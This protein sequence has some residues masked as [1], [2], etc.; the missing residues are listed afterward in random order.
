[1]KHVKK[2]FIAIMVFIMAITIVP[3][4]IST[5]KNKIRL[6]K[7]SV[8]LNIGEKTTLKVKGTSKKI[9]W[10][11]L[12]KKIATV[13]KKGVVKGK[14][15]G[16]TIIIAKV[17]KNQYACKI[18]VEDKED[19]NDSD[20]DYY[21][22]SDDESSNPYYDDG[23][24]PPTPKPTVAPTPK[25]TIIPTVKPTVIQEQNNI[26]YMGDVAINYNSANSE[27]RIFFS[28]KTSNGTRIA[29]LG[30][31]NITIINNNNI[32]VYKKDI[33]FIKNNFSNWTNSD[34]T[35]YL[36]CLK[37]PDLDIVAG[38]ISTG[39]IYLTVKTETGSRFE[40]EPYTI[41]HLPLFKYSSQCS[42]IIDD[43]TVWYNKE[44]NLY[45]ITDVSYNFKDTNIPGKVNLIIEYTGTRIAKTYDLFFYDI[46]LYLNDIL[47]DTRSMTTSTYEGEVEKKTVTFFNIDAGYYHVKFTSKN[48]TTINNTTSIPTSAPTSTTKPSYDN[49][50]GYGTVSGNITYHY[51]QYMGYVADTGARVILIPKDG[52]AKSSDISEVLF[53]VLTEKTLRDKNIYSA[54]V[55]GAGNYSVNHIPEGEYLIFIISNKCSTG[56]WFAAYDDTISDAA[57]TYYKNI[58][59]DSGLNLYLNDTT[60]FNLV[61]SIIFYDYKFSSI[62]VYGNSNTTVSHAF[63]YTYT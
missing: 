54:K 38:D 53:S 26:K 56:L 36:C 62:S 46:R 48:S 7:T 13:S 2:M 3:S 51:N 52:S 49:N 5:A 45:S 21:D 63:P 35:F 15:E 33:D 1:M 50:V 55:D 25:P 10:S 39:K 44:T 9:K 41:N 40:T 28:L 24:I 11:S 60:S 20:D 32:E 34:G 61:K 16:I 8:T 22:D 29:S 58:I 43:G 4:N 18:K 6:N 17:L 14:K 30:T 59:N 23:Y 31:A 12:N 19:D 37:I 27:H 47:I 57:D 42:C